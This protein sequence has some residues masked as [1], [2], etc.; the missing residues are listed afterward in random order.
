MH[1]RTY[2]SLDKP[3]PWLCDFIVRYRYV[4]ELCVSLQLNSETWSHPHAISASTVASSSVAPLLSVALTPP[5]IPSCFIGGFRGSAGSV[6]GRVPGARLAALI[7]HAGIAKSIF[8]LITGMSMV[9]LRKF[10]DEV[11]SKRALRA[12]NG[13]GPYPAPRLCVETYLAPHR[14]QDAFSGTGRMPVLSVR[15]SEMVLPASISLT[16]ARL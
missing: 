8:C 16:S 12:V 2:L 4:R 13:R 7:G 11:S 6:N 15:S 1:G 14:G 10:T 5:L 9:Q 3:P